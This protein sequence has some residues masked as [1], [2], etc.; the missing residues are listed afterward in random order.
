M[1]PLNL[2]FLSALALAGAPLAAAPAHPAP[3]RAGRAVFERVSA[4]DKGFG[5]YQADV[6]ML[7]KGASGSTQT[8]RMRV[9]VLED[10]VGGF[11]S[12]I[13][14]DSPLDVQGTEILTR[15]TGAGRD[16][17]WIFLPA[18]NRVRQIS[19]S[20]RTAAFMG[21]QFSYEDVDSLNVV[22][23]RYA[24]G[25]PTSVALD[26]RP[27]EE[28]ACVPRHAG[29]AYSRL[30]AWVDAVD[31]VVRRIDYYGPSGG[32]LKTLALD[33]YARHDGGHWRASR[34]TMTD[35]TDAKVTVMEWSRFRFGTGLGRAA[36]DPST[37]A[38]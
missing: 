36:F 20:D 15:S 38:R 27:C 1:N 25:P 22:V 6:T 26:G 18:F 24:Y 14:F 16:E 2:V 23:D 3:S 37:L 4:G 9:A 17:Q 31:P 19:G 28:V 13:V 35:R 21:S 7:L 8:R 29:S 5:D 34:M 10:P 32:L 30:V 12:L 11:R 33:G